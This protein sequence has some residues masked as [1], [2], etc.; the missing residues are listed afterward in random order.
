MP[1]VISTGFGCKACG[2]RFAWKPALAG[3]RVKCSCGNVLTVPATAP[4]V[5]A[6]PAAVAHS[7]PPPGAHGGMDLSAL[8]EAAIAPAQD[9]G[10][11][12][13]SCQSNL[14]PGTIVCTTCGFNLRTGQKTGAGATRAAVLP[15]HAPA[16]D[17]PMIPGCASR[18][19]ARPVDSSDK[20]KII[21][22]AGGL[23]LVVAA[24]IA[25]KFLAGGAGAQK[26]MLGDDGKVIQA[27]KD[28]G[29]QDLE[30]WIGDG[31][32]RMVMG[33]N[34]GQALF[35]AKKLKELVLAASSPLAGCSAA[36][37]PLSCPAI[38]NSVSPSLNGPPTGTKNCRKSRRMMSDSSISGS[39]CTSDLR[40]EKSAFRLC[41]VTPASPASARWIKPSI[42]RPLSSLFPWRSW[43]PWR[44]TSSESEGA[45]RLVAGQ[46]TLFDRPRGCRNAAFCSGI[47]TSG[48]VAFRAAAAATI[49]AT[50]ELMVL[51][52]M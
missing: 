32:Q 45:V 8:E 38:P 5:V 50:C 14:I 49:F 18:P 10:Y 36:P 47:R 23:A 30:A 29:G 42:H 2:R 46:D 35:T 40:Y 33:M 52:L 21:L 28:E 1:E 15:A 11:R 3:K 6:R 51:I 44:S 24:V 7:A 17:G 19:A 27:I 25:Y 12:C 39:I 31:S 22:A 26:A 48:G 4:A 41:F 37:W 34:Q 13:P 20:T 43:R 16:A 9:T